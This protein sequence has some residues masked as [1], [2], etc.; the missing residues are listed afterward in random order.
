MDAHRIRCTTLLAASL[1]LVATRASA[2]VFRGEAIPVTTSVDPVEL[3][4]FRFLT[5]TFGRKGPMETPLRTL[6]VRGREYFVDARP[7]N[8]SSTSRPVAAEA[9]SPAA[10]PP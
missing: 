5:F 4:E 3:S 6:T 9:A 7:Q 8:L 10:S 1:V 2:Q